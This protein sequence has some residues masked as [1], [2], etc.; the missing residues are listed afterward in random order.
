MG[1]ASKLLHDGSENEMALGV[2]SVVDGGMD[3][4]EFLGLALAFEALHFALAPSK[5]KMRIPSLYNYLSN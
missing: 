3:G 1:D 2:A 4:E 5:R